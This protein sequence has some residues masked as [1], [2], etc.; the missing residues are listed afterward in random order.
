MADGSEAL[1]P[2]RKLASHEPSPFREVVEY[3]TR[4]GRPMGESDEHRDEM[5]HYGT[6]PLS[7]A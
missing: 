3:P 6:S 5:Q 7:T 1:V 2:R 4:D